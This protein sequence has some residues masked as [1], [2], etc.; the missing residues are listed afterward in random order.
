MRHHERTGVACAARR[1]GVLVDAAAPVCDNPRP[2]P[3]A[4]R[5]LLVAALFASG[6]ALLKAC[7]LPSLQRAAMRAAVA[8]VVVFALLPETRRWPN[9]RILRVLPV[10]FGST[11]LFV[12]ATSLTT[13]ANAIFL[14]SA[15]PLW[16]VLLSPWLLGERPTRADVL[17]LLG[18]GAGMTL[19]FVAPA[20]AQATAPHPRLGDWIAVVSGIS[21]ALL[22]IGMRW[23]ARSGAAEQSSVVAWGNALTCPLAFLLMPVFGQELVAGRVQDWVVIVVLGV[24]QVGLAYAILVRTIAHV[25]ALRAALIMMVEPVLNSLA[26]WLVHGEVPHPIA[27]AGGVLIL[28]T[29]ALG[30][31]RRPAP[32]DEAAAPNAP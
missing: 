24:F 6:G 19:F 21:Y 9:A 27:A 28:A 7:E 22:L 5:L 4:F 15:A 23:L 26:T 2:V 13:A 8:A 11:C 30:A 14:Q 32:A 29:V 18:V 16:L 17:T 20:E 10:Y 1:D 31:L 12:V 3:H 25:P